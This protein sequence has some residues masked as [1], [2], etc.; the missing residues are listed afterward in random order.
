MFSRRTQCL[1]HVCF[2][3][4]APNIFLSLQT[5]V[6][7]ATIAASKRVSSLCV[8]VGM[9]FVFV[10]CCRAHEFNSPLAILKRALLNPASDAKYPHSSHVF[11]NM[12]KY[13]LCSALE[14]SLWISL[15]C[16]SRFVW[17]F[18]AARLHGCI[19]FE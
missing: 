18:A 13:A 9:M 6:R 2:T 7:L 3:P 12:T 1:V 4:L 19:G 8:L 10:L 11:G 15:H 16:V 14:D 5:Q 17:R